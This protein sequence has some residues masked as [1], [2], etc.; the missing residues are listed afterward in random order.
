[1]LQDPQQRGP[2]A[3]VVQA[4]VQEGL[5]QVAGAEDLGRAFERDAD[6]AVDHPVDERLEP[7]LLLG[8]AIGGDA[9]RGR[10]RHGDPAPAAIGFPIIERGD[11]ILEEAGEIGDILDRAL[12]IAAAFGKAK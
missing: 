4:S 9:Q 3:Q 6:L 2:V 1:M 10:D 8:L 11:H 5:K 7:S 12:E